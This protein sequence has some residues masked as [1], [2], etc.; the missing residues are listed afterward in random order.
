MTFLEI[1]DHV[2]QLT[3][4]EREQLAQH[5]QL[6]ALANDPAHRAE[7]TRRMDRIEAGELLVG[8]DEVKRLLAERR[9][10]NV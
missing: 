4:E 9:A 5:L 3:A 10:V 8:P 1:K 7:M 2:A 6:I